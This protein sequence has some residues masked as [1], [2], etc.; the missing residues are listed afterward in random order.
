MTNTW[1]V[2]YELLEA[3]IAEGWANN[4]FGVA[5]SACTRIR[6]LVDKILCQ[7]PEWTQ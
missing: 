1:D 5:F 7:V 6:E 2:Q 4:A 3:F